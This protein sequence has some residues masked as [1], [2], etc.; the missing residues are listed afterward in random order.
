MK[1]FY[2][3]NNGQVCCIVC[4]NP[5]LLMTGVASLKA[6]DEPYENGKEEK[7]KEVSEKEIGI[8]AHYCETCDKFIE[9]AEE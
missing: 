8:I 5:T 3:N 4:E 1:D 6:H 2:L 9:I 7:P